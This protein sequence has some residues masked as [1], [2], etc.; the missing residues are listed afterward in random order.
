MTAGVNIN[1]DEDALFRRIT[2]KIVP[3]LFICYVIAYID[4]ANIG[5]AKLQML[6]DLHFDAAIYGFG[7]GIFFIGF[8]L[9][10]L[11]SNLF[12]YRLGARVWLARIMITWGIISVLMLF[13]NTEWSFYVLRFLLGAAE[14]GFFPGVIY[15][16]TLWYPDNRRGRIFSTFA[17]GAT[18]GGLI[19]GPLSGW[20]MQNFHEVA[21]LRGWQWL[22]VLQ[23]LPAILLG[24]LL[25]VFLSDSP[26]TAKWMAPEDRALL[27]E[28]LAGARAR[29]HDNPNFW[30][31]F[32]NKSIWLL[33]LVL[34]ATN[35]GIYLGV[36][37][38]P[39]IIKDAGITNLQTIGNISSI[40]YI[41]AAVAMFGLGRS[42]DYF[43]DR[44]WHIAI[45]LIL[46]AAALTVSAFVSQ[47]SV[48]A[49]GGVVIA[50][51]LLIGVTPLLWVHA[52][53]FIDGKTAAA[54]FALIN[55]CASVCAF[56]GPYVTGLSQ[57]Q[58]GST[59]LAFTGI[60]GAVVIAALALIVAPGLSPAKALPRTA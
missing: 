4:R 55:M 22:F 50:T 54:G 36:F 57:Q 48:G 26:T 2:Y 23:G 45:S 30:T 56:L 17:I 53:S 1:I 21:G 15:Y 27:N 41:T 32:G 52:S 37:W 6:D 28:K 46:G 13:I 60:A 59:A 9:A 38:L 7:A 12:L 24:G 16:L 8:T 42:S 51:G 31:V 19:V 39:T 58:L 43:G 25:F 29:K 49:I 20:I 44:R 35:L 18:V 33:G 47:A 5:F 3:I 14:A 10:E 34:G 40:P 11:P